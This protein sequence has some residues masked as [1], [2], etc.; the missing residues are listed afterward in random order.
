MYYN[1]QSKRV[2]PLPGI[3]SLSYVVISDCL[4]HDAVAVHCFEKKLL[5][6]LNGILNLKKVYYF[7]DGAAAQYKNK[8][9][10]VNLAFHVKDF[11]IEA[12]RH[13]FAT[14][15]GK[16]APD[17]LGGTLKRQAARASLQRPLNGQIQTPK[18]LYEWA[19]EALL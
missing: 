14:A 8:K 15:H 10:F 11:I 18:Q 16:G 5:G 4:A 12:E 17:G 2:D 3:H 6:F 13:F 1:G 7:T 19:K 9:N